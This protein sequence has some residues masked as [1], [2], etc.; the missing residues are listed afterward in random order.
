MRVPRAIGWV[1]LAVGLGMVIASVGVLPAMSVAQPALPPSISGSTVIQLPPCN[2]QTT[3]D[4]TLSQS[5]SAT[6]LT[7]DQA[8][9]VY[10]AIGEASGSF[11]TCGLIAFY[12]STLTSPDMLPGG[13]SSESVLFYGGVQ[14]VSPALSGYPGT[15][16]TPYVHYSTAD[17][18]GTYGSASISTSA[19]SSSS[20]RSTT[21]TTSTSSTSITTTSTATQAF[22][23]AGSTTAATSPGPYGGPG[24]VDYPLSALGSIL[25]LAGVVVSARGK[26]P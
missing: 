4:C 2:G 7:P 5:W 10:V 3:N 15:G 13:P 20:S 24:P 16:S 26:L 19:T 25:A 17:G 1:L 9:A 21:T 12:S 11:N 6:L 8:A 18:C 14:L 22:V 23:T